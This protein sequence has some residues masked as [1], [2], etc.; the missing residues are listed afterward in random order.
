LA[1]VVVVS[2]SAPVAMSQM[3]ALWSVAVTMRDPSTVKRALMTG[4]A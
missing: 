3:V 1:T 4:A 2:S